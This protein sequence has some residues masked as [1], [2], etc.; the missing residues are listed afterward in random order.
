M[1][2]FSIVPGLTFVDRRGWRADKDLPRKGRKV[3]RSRRTHMI[4]HHTVIIDGDDR[5]PNLWERESAIFKNMR[6]LQVVRESD[7]G[8]DVPYNFVAYFVKK[9]DGVYICEGRGEDRTGAHTKGHNTSGIAI[10]IAGDFENETISGIE[11]S[12]RM[13]L[14]SAFMGWLK[15]G[16]SHDEYGKFK[17]MKNLGSLQPQGRRVFFHKDFKNT[18]CPGKL[19]EPHLTQLE[20]VNPQGL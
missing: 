14:I 8:A 15:F 11:F 16:P 20:F 17:P 9:G 5:T 19:I 10:S 1:A 12:K 6:K 4:I 2:K 18:A 7:L 3:A 13:H